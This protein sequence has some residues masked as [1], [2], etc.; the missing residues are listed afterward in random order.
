MARLDARIL[1]KGSM[2][3]GEGNIAYIDDNKIYS[4]GSFSIRMPETETSTP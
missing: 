1:H 4:A 3:N 2:T